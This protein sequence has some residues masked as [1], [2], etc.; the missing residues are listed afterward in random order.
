MNATTIEVKWNKPYAH[1]KYDVTSYTL[2]IWNTSSKSYVLE[3]EI[4]LAN[5]AVEYYV[6]KD[7]SKPDVCHYL[8]FR[9]TAS[10]E[11]G[12]SNVGLITGSFPI[13]KINLVQ[14][15]ICIL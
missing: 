9:L 5:E 7:G 12:T 13:G 10:N 3:D 2:S 4:F 11:A 15:C 8:E 14:S 6:T 1:P